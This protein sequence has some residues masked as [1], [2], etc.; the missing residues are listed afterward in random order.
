MQ[1]GLLIANIV[2]LSTRATQDIDVTLQSMPMTKQGI[3]EMVTEIIEIDT[4]DNVFFELIDVTTIREEADYEG[5]RC[6]LSGRQGTMI[7]PFRIDF[8]TGDTIT[9]GATDFVYHCMIGD[10]TIDLLSYNLETVL[11][12][13]LQT[14][15]ARSITNTRLRDYYDIHILWCMH[16]KD[17]NTDTLSDALKATTKQRGTESDLSNFKSLI[18]SI[19]INQKMSSR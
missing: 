11:A 10:E 4:K 12:E 17:I 14:C 9:P 8:S 7:I 1:G 16:K 3:Q 18:D 5:Y 15:L 6:R 2:G 19:K 13:K